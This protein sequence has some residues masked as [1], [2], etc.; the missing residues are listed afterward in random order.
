MFPSNLTLEDMNA[1]KSFLKF[2]KPFDVK[3]L[4]ILAV[5]TSGFF[6]QP[7]QLM[8]EMLVD[9]KELAKD[10]DCQTH[11]LSDYSVEAGVRHF[12]EKFNIELIGISNMVKHPLKRIF[13]GSNVEMLVNHSEVPV[14][15]IDRK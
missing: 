15:S 4:H 3:E 10:Y 12:S 8:L 6:N 7:A 2:L 14:L 9:F 5:N 1:F 11:F 13:Q